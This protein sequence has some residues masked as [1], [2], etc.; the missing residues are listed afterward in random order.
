MRIG[1]CPKCNHS[2]EHKPINTW[3]YVAEYYCKRC[4][5]WFFSHNLKGEGG[6]T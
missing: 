5:E 3:C 4:D 6:N 1:K 2:L